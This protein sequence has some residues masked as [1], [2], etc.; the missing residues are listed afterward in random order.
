MTNDEDFD[1]DDLLPVEPEDPLTAGNAA[2]PGIDLSDFDDEFDEDFEAEVVGEYEMDDDEFAR[3][4]VDMVDFE[5]EGLSGSEEVA[6][7]EGTLDLDVD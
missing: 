1:G 3:Q 4:L 6:D 7:T 5:I 2:L